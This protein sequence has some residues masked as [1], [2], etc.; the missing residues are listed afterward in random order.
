MDNARD[1]L[2]QVCGNRST[3]LLLEYLLA[4]YAAKKRR[5]PDCEDT[6][7][8]ML[9]AF[10]QE[11]LASK[12][13]LSTRTIMRAIA[14]LRSLRLL[15]VSQASGYDRSYRYQINQEALKAVYQPMPL[16]DSTC[17]EYDHARASDENEDDA[18]HGDK[19]SHSMVKNCHDA[20]RHNVT[21]EHDRMSPCISFLSLPL[22]P[23]LTSVGAADATQQKAEETQAARVLSLPA[24]EGVK[25]Q[26]TPSSEDADKQ[27]IVEQCRAIG[28][29]KERTE[30]LL[31]EHSRRD[32]HAALEFV[33][34][35]V[36]RMGARYQ[37]AAVLIDF[38]RRPWQYGYERDAHGVLVSAR[39]MQS[40]ASKKSEQQQLEL[41]E[42]EQQRR[43]AE[44][45]WQSLPYSEQLSI[46]T[47][48]D[49][50]NSE[51]TQAVRLSLYHQEAL[52]RSKQ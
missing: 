13:L 19:M 36:K 45:A 7:E 48:I 30:L 14:K 12:M 29:A 46:R 8:R 28:I 31:T 3:A 22:I 4:V 33:R 51:K 39:A 21:I 35:A 15:I 52:R 43:A 47:T 41:S 11:Q 40:R 23:S 2:L 9:L 5:Y 37:P 32:M 16:F 25:P 6:D 42:S 49:S 27:S 26:T 10:T 1:Q 34:S 38:M 20:T 17:D 44:T 18:R 50:V 24:H